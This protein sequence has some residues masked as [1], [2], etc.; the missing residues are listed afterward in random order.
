MSGSPAEPH[1]FRS[2]RNQ[3]ASDQTADEGKRDSQSISIQ[4]HDDLRS[5]AGV[6]SGIF[7]NENAERHESQAALVPVDERHRLDVFSAR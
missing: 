7:P 4:P 1:V 5:E 2:R 6:R 3:A